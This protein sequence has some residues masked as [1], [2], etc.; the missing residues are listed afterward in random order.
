VNV[1]RIEGA[2]GRKGVTPALI[3]LAALA[4]YFPALH[5]YYLH[6]DDYLD[7]HWGGFSRDSIL[8]RYGALGRPLTGF[9]LCLGSHITSIAAMNAVRFGTV[10]ELS[11]FGWLIFRWLRMWRVSPLPALM[12][13]VMVLTLPP[14]QSYVAFAILMPAGLAA[15]V[16]M[17]AL[18]QAYRATR[19]RAPLGP[20]AFAML[21]LMISLC[22]YQPVALLFL[23]MLAAPV[24]LSDSSSFI[25]DWRK[26][27]LIYGTIL[28][29]AMLVYYFLWRMWLLAYDVRMGPGYD[30]RSMVTDYAGRLL[31]FVTD[32]LF[33]AANFWAIWPS[34]L[35]AVITALLVA[36]GIGADFVEACE[37]KGR[38]SAANFAAKYAVVL[39]LVPASY[40][41]NLASAAPSAEYRTYPALSTVLLVVA[42]LWACRR[43]SGSALP[44]S[45]NALL[46][47]TFSMLA[48]AGIFEAHRTVD[49]YFVRPDTAEFEHVKALIANYVQAKGM[50]KSIHV[51][52]LPLG[53][54]S[55]LQRSEFG[56]MTL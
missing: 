45:R 17:A 36:I 25:K 10:V 4:A 12:A 2:L 55:A 20:G 8:L 56:A 29:S 19:S 18:F 32:P 49:E 22:L 50:P 3:F 14:F 52:L 37:G 23:A 40:G 28:F 1:E 41:I 26:P 33:E 43:V 16:A 42:L 15:A 35:I 51:I 21:L 6:T 31:W 9:L 7:T 24:V 48:L 53:R 34:P 44:R 27:L 30:A 38:S 5:G 11:V 39:L 46:A 54:H 47:G 13:S